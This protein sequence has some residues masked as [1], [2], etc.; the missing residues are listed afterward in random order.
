MGKICLQ[1]YANCIAKC[2][3]GLYEKICGKI[4][5]IRGCNR[6]RTFSLAVAHA[7]FVS[8][9]LLG[10][11]LSVISTALTKDNIIELMQIRNI[12][13]MHM[14]LILLHVFVHI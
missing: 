9:A 7:C 11:K 5:F 2:A 8:V 3:K 1:R 10:I 14:V 4:F 12:S 6:R 13:S